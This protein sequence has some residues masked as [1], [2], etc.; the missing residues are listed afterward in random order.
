[1]LARWGM[2]FDVTGRNMRYVTKLA[3]VDYKINLHALSTQ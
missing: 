2:C 1:M 3:H